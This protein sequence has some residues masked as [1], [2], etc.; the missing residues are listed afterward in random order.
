MI[1]SHHARALQLFGYLAHLQKNIS[2][3]CDFHFSF[4]LYAGIIVKQLNKMFFVFFTFHFS[5]LF[6]VFFPRC[7]S[8]LWSPLY[9]PVALPRCWVKVLEPTVAKTDDLGLVPIFKKIVQT[10]SVIFIFSFD[11]YADIISKQLQK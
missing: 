5:L 11:L 4:D 6:P 9:Y 2:K 10:K 7:A 3:I 8:L 1:L